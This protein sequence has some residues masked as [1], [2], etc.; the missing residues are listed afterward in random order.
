MIKIR[1]NKAFLGAVQIELLGKYSDTSI[2]ITYFEEHICYI[3][4]P[5]GTQDVEKFLFNHSAICKTDWNGNIFEFGM[6]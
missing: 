5:Y 3:Y 4:C 1:R 6:C 2:I